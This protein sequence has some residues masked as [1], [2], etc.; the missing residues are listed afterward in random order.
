M[1]IAKFIKD[2]WLVYI[3]WGVFNSLTLFILWLTPDYPFHWSII[4]YLFFIQGLFFVFFQVL[5]YLMK[6]HWWQKF[7][8]IKEESLLQ[9]FFKG[10]RSEEEKVQQLVMNQMI[11][12]HQETMQQVI[13][14][15][16]EQKDYIDSWVHEIKVPLAASQLL[17]KSVEFDLPDEKFMAMENELSRMNDYVEQVLYVAR[18]ESFTKDY[19]IQESSLKEIIQPVIR[20][21]ANY[22][23][24]KNVRFAVEGDDQT[25][26]TD[27]KWVAFIFRQLLANAIKYTDAGGMIQILLQTTAQEVQLSICDNGIGIPSEDLNRIFDKGFTGSNGRNDQIHS[28]GLGLYLVQKLSQ[29]L[30]IGVSVTSTVGKGTT[31]ALHFSRLHY[32]QEVR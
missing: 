14:N 25:I 21:Q 26:L 2:Q 17:L 28:T 18:L 27:G 24:Q 5:Y 23:I 13:A 22:F 3:A 15:Q 16:E 7:A 19:L 29:K 9:N 32:Y 31:I 30:G 6:R 8:I 12:E 20:S 11:T 10:A 1:T 4:G